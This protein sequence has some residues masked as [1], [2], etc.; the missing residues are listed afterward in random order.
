MSSLISAQALKKR[1]DQ[2][3]ALH[4]LDATYGARPFGDN[5]IPGSLRF[6]I[7]M[8][9]DP[10]APLPH[11]APK[12]EMIEPMMGDLGIRE[13]DTL[14]IYD[15][16]GIH[17]A[18]S[19]V[20]WM[21]RLFGHKGSVYVLNG[22]LKGW[23]ASGF[24]T[25]HGHAR[26]KPQPYHAAYH[27]DLI[28]IYDD[29]TQAGDAVTILDARDQ[30]RFSHAH[31]PGSLNL[32]FPTLLCENG[33]KLRPVDQLHGILKDLPEQPVIAS[34]GSGV[35]ACVIALALHEIKRNNVSVYDGSWS[36]YSTKL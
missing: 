22:G 13:T 32:P 28:R 1:L 10:D 8:I 5:V 18:A 14:V 24:D 9:A 36:E 19:R 23:V 2:G 15:Q 17:M 35:T 26:P 6:D 12:P 29:V 21:T 3:E 16:H 4:I 20:W 34:C 30:E 31:I 7:D 11:T 25:D 27:D 33:T